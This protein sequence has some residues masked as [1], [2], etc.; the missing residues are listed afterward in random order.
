MNMTK[1]LY[2]DYG[3]SLGRESNG[4][5]RLRRIVVGKIPSIIL[6][7]GSV[8]YKS[9]IPSG[10]FLVFDTSGQVPFRPGGTHPR[11]NYSIWGC[12]NQGGKNE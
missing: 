10:F 1:A 11:Q 4:E 5:L 8:K 7:I 6:N 9:N 3:I 2:E 12:D